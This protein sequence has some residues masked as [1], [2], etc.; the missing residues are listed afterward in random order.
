MTNLTWRKSSVVV[1]VALAA[2]TACSGTIGSDLAA[3]RKTGGRDPDPATTGNGTGTATS[4]GTG[5]GSGVGGSG[6]GGTGTGGSAGTGGGTVVC[7]GGQAATQMRTGAL[8][9]RRLTRTEY[10]NTIRDLLGD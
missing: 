1:G 4:T 6:G 9:M 10:N 8:P 7:A 3:K 5:T 2:W